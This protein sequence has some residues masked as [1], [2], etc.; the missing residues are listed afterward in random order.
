MPTNTGIAAARIH[1]VLGVRGLVMNQN[2][3]IFTMV[4]ENS[5]NP[6][7]QNMT[8]SDPT[9]SADQPPDRYLRN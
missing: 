3:M 9:M 1:G 4:G 7:L 5:S 6:Y 2:I 8:L